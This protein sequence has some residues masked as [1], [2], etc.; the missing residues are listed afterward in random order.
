M[1]EFLFAVALVVISQ[2]LNK[3]FYNLILGATEEE[4]T[5]NSYLE[6]FIRTLPLVM[7]SVSFQFVLATVYL[8][9]LSQANVPYLRKIIVLSFVLPSLT[10]MLPSR[11]NNIILGLEDCY[12]FL[13]AHLGMVVLFNTTKVLLFACLFLT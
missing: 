12:F 11:K 10:L 8:M 4:E 5:W 9:I 1:Y 7:S 6:R 2:H 3:N 13:I